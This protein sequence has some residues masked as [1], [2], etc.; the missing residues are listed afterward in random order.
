MKKF[1]DVEKTD[2][3]AQGSG[4]RLGPPCFVARPG[5][6]GGGRRDQLRQPLPA[7]AGISA[8]R[9]PRH[10]HRRGGP[11]HRGAPPP[12]RGAEGVSVP[13][14]RQR[15]RAGRDVH[16]RVLRRRQSL[17]PV[18]GGDDQPSRARLL[19]HRPRVQ[20]CSQRRL[21]ERR[22]QRRAGR[23]GVDRRRPLGGPRHLRRLH[24]R[25]D[26]VPR[27]A[28]AR[29]R[30]S[31]PG[32]PR[33]RGGGP[34]A[35]D[36]AARVGARDLPRRGRTTSES[37]RSASPTSSSS[38]GGCWHSL[39]DGAFSANHSYY[40]CSGLSEVLGG[41][42]RLVPQL[43]ALPVVPERHPHVSGP[44]AG[45]PPAHRGLHGADGKELAREAA[46]WRAPGRGCS[47]PTWPPWRAA[48]GSRRRT[49]AF[50]VYAD[51]P[52]GAAVPCRANH[53]L[54]YSSGL[55]VDQRVPLQ[56]ERLHPSGRD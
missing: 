24:L 29:P 1:K 3:G 41:R 33:R 22:D 25:A 21:R 26:R 8:R 37:S 10:R 56:S 31:R 16:G 45:R 35:A 43:S 34:A 4:A 32:V 54:A 11:A 42:P 14:D 6:P 52:N 20:P 17:H 7:E 9:V 39:P 48:P 12:D 15:R 51:A 49:C 55:L 46:A 50:V 44:V 19:Q 30:D 13:A 18:P 53:R 47:R 40:D 28:G 38:M 2:P 23:G 36:P 5:A 27:G